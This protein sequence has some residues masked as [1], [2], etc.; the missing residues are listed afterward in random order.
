MLE[1][2]ANPVEKKHLS[3]IDPIS[4]ACPSFWELMMDSRSCGA[5]HVCIYIYIYVFINVYIYI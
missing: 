2:P 3:P 5:V 1:Y 4:Q